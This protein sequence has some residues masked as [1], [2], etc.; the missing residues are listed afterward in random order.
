MTRVEETCVRSD[1]EGDVLT[2]HSEECVE[3]GVK[4]ENKLV[5]EEDRIVGFGSLLTIIS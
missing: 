5:G 2:R 1:L 3:G 4:S